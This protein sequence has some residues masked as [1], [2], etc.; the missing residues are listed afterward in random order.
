MHASGLGVKQDS[1]AAL[2]WY[3]QAA[4]RG[5][6]NAQVNFGVAC[7]EGQVDGQGCAEAA[8]WYRRAA[9]R[10]RFELHTRPGSPRGTGLEAPRNSVG[11]AKWFRVGSVYLGQ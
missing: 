3:R 5:D 9:A 7:Y 10:G 4:A 1:A 8:K 2:K 11:N 6:A